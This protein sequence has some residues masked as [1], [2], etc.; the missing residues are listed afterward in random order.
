MP[1]H[2]IR[3]GPF[4]FGLSIWSPE[5]WPHWIDVER[6]VDEVILTLRIP[7]DLKKEDIKVEFREGQLRIRFPRRDGEWEPIK[8]E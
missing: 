5:W 2:F 3:F 1:C 6:T 8:I 7:R 4:G